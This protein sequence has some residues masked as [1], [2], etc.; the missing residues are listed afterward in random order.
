MNKLSPEGLALMSLGTPRRSQRS[1]TEKVQL[2][3]LR[4]FS[5][6]FAKPSNHQSGIQFN[7]LSLLNREKY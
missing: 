6:L 1:T 5:N 7:W 2:A 4:V 3:A